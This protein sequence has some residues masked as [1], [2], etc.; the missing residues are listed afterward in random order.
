MKNICI[1]LF[2][3]CDN[4]RWRDSFMKAYN[5]LGIN[6]F[7]PMVDNWD[8]SMVPIEADHLKNDEI[9]LFP[10][11]KDSYGIGS[12]AEVA[13]GPLKDIIAFRNRTFIILIDDDVNETLQN[14]KAM[15]KA[16]KRARALVKGHLKDI[17]LKNLHIVSTLEEMLDLSLE[18]YKFILDA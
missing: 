15:A 3:T 12:L 5:N 16:S 17:G 11:L 6:Y 4:V 1:G 9:I 13:F 10:I 14:D 8:A 7:N 2:G 18:M